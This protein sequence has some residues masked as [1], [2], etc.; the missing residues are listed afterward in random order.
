MKGDKGTCNIGFGSNAVRRTKF[1]T[2]KNC[3][4]AFNA[5]VDMGIV[6]SKYVVYKCKEC[7]MWHFGKVEWAELYS[8]K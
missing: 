3:T 8:E 2:E 1:D 7:G 4:A 5:H 6:S